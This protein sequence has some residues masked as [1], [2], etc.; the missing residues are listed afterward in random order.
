M[1]DITMCDNES[2]P[3]KE[4][5]HRFTANPSTWQSYADFYVPD[6]VCLDF[7]PMDEELEDGQKN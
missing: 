7:L 1:P 5:C 4:F 3:S 6:E 2:C